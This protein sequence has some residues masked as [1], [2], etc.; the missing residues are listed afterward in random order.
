MPRPKNGVASELARLA[1]SEGA[2]APLGIN[3]SKTAH[4][5]LTGVL[6]GA[7]PLPWN[8]CAFDTAAESL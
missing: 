7:G 8:V 3:H 1:M 2:T 5:S 6:Q 4:R